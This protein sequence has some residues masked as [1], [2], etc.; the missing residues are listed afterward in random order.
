ML[1]R[2]L[3][4]LVLLLAAAPLRA[5]PA[6]IACTDLLAWARQAGD[7]D[8]LALTRGWPALAPRREVVLP[9]LFLAPV[10]AETF[11]QSATAWDRDTLRAVSRRLRACARDRALRDQAAVFNTARALLDGDAARFLR[12][13]E[14]SRG[15]VAEQLAR[16]EQAAFAPGILPFL[17]ALPEATQ[18][19]GHAVALRLAGGLPP[20]I[21]GTGRL[22]LRE[23]PYLLQAD[24][25]ATLRPRLASQIAARQAQA[26]QAVAAALAALPATP[27]GLAQ[28]DALAD[29]PLEAALE[30]ADRPGFAAARA[31][32]REALLARMEEG[33]RQRLAQLAVGPARPAQLAQLDRL[34]Q[35]PA[36]AA[37][38]AARRRAMEAEIAGLGR[39]LAS[40]VMQANREALAVRPVN[41]PTL[42]V[43]APAQAR[44]LQALEAYAE[45]A[46]LA[47]FREESGTALAALAED[48]FPDFA[49]RLAALPV[50]EEGLRLL[51]QPPPWLDSLPPQAAA[52]EAR[53]R[54][55][56]AARRGA[57]E[58]GLAA[59]A[60][61]EAAAEAGPLTG[62][63][64]AAG[65]GR[66]R[67]EFL[68]SGRVLATQA[69]TTRAGTYE[70]IAGERVIITLPDTN[71]VLRRAG[72]R[73]DGG[74]V[75]LER[76]ASP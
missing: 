76:V 48:A 17:R 13:R 2:F 32:R 45:P 43:A 44:L 38:P 73:L 74:A 67:L 15:R 59:A 18:P 55:A 53:F 34:R 4:S 70:E 47:R 72:R 60:A 71:L 16:L 9:G 62:R 25:E 52:Q 22:L 1:P 58:A 40:Q 3:L 19:M 29:G 68:D 57:I 12:Q 63:H 7:H 61:A 37:L 50:G 20:Q 36:L 35:D 8:S 54:D 51:R 39:R 27:R 75:V 11:G 6:D 64:Y 10:T 41:L 33:L 23:V 42:A 69:E 46:A 56:L 28:L 14:R 30:A 21:R 49:A 66:L 5:A 26:R 24:I 31:A 65:D